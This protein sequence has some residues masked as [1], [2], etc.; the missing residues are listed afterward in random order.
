MADNTSVCPVCGRPATRSNSLP[1][2]VTTVSCSAQCGTFRVVT[3]FLPELAHARGGEGVLASRLDEL[4]RALQGRAVTQL[5]NENQVLAALDQFT[6]A[7]TS[8]E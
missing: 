5:V 3:D 6:D 4:S 1:Y 7:E 8:T 2:P